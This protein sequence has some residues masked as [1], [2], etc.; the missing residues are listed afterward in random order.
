MI[1]DREEHQLEQR[2]IIRLFPLAT[3]CAGCKEEI[4]DSGRWWAW[5][6]ITISV[7]FSLYKVSFYGKKRK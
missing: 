7:F 1:I 3:W 4:R 5:D 6:I 2:M